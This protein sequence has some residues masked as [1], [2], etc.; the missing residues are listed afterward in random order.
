M[1]KL[2]LLITFIFSHVSGANSFHISPEGT[3]SG[4]GS[5]ES[6]WDLQTALNGPADVNAGDTLWLRG[7]TYEGTY[8]SRLEGSQEAPVIV[9]QYPGE[10]AILDGGSS[11]DA[12]LA[13]SGSYA[14]FWGFEVM[15]SDPDRITSSTGSF[16]TDLTRG[17][18]II[19][20]QSEGSAGGVRFINLIIHDCSQG[21]G[22]WKTA[23]NSEIYG[24]IIYHNGW[25]SDDR[26]HG[27]GIY[28]QNDAG[29]KRLVDNI[30][31]NQFSHGIHAY[32]SA[33][34]Y[35]N[36]FYM[37]GNISFNNGLIS[38]TSGF[39]R[40]FLLGGGRIAENNVLRNNFSYFTSGVNQGDN[41]TGYSAG[42]QNLTIEGN[43]FAGGSSPLRFVNCSQVTM[44]G[45]SFIGQVGGF[46][47]TDFPD[48]TY[49]TETPSGVHAV[50]RPNLYE[51]G[52]AIIVVYN[53]D[54]LSEIDVDV[55]EVLGTG[56]VY[57][58]RDV[59]NYFG[60]PVAT[61][62]FQGGTISVPMNLS[63][64][65]GP[66]GNAPV[67]PEHTGPEF[68]VFVLVR[69]EISSGSRRTPAKADADF[70]DCSFNYGSGL[71]RLTVTS[72]GNHVLLL[73]DCRGKTIHTWRGK[74]H[75]FYD[76]SLSALPKGLY[77]LTGKGNTHLK[78]I[79][80][81]SLL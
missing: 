43:Y 46:S 72:P 39:S 62:T 47:E 4:N 13:V 30:I 16:P 57:E 36:N 65:S 19:T 24:N 55:S 40:N 9:R 32:G 3:S 73:R 68:G 81:F 31:F 23:L 45:N 75:V 63:L 10:R 54:Q 15:S 53:W 35:L 1:L 27:H 67:Q 66:V 17:T 51:P 56:D 61:G 48:N 79:K 18:G 52:R 11:T 5:P 14:W 33:N 21:Y 42:A 8:V 80:L 34:A 20:S 29:T 2:L 22:F 49:S 25:D 76:I 74:G 38:E 26:G 64:A 59:Q 69:T 71:Y 6:S 28:T 50:I 44:T 37:E 60:D 58:V 12:V 7:G 77:L 41:N 70:M 78:T